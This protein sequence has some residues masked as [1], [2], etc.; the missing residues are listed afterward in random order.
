MAD[1][2]VA[3][4]ALALLEAELRNFVDFRLGVEMV[5]EIYGLS[6]D[7]FFGYALKSLKGPMDGVIGEV[8][9]FVTSVLVSTVRAQNE[10][11]QRLELALRGRV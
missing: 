9:L 6:I 5:G 8:R 11:I 4:K 2:L 7:E 10:K 3:D 1:I